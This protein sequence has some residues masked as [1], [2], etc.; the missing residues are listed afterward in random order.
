MRSDR[1][2]DDLPEPDSPL[3][4][5]SAYDLIRRFAVFA[6]LDGDVAAEIAPSLEWISLPGGAD[7]FRRGE[8]SDCAYLL[9]YGT[10]GVFADAQ[11]APVARI[12]AGETVGEMG[13]VLGR[14][15]S[16]T[17]RAL[18]DSDLVRIPGEALQRAL[19]RH[20]QALLA[21]ARIAIDRVEDG[22]GSGAR[23]SHPRTIALVPASADIDV[24]GFAVELV[25]ALARYGRAEL[26]WSVRGDDHSSGWFH[27]IEAR[28]EFVVYAGEAGASAWTGLCVRQADA[29][30]L[31]VRAGAPPA[32]W[33]ALA[34]RRL[35]HQRTELVMLHED[36][37][38]PGESARQRPATGGEVVH[39]V[40]GSEDI[41]RIARLLTG[42]ACGVVLSG[43]G[44][45]GFAHIGV[46]RAL[47]ERGVPI[48]C[49]GGTSIGAIIAAG[50]ALGWTD[51]EL[52][53]RMRACFVETNPL[54]D[55]TLPLVSLVAGRKVAAM[56][57][58]EFGG[59]DIEDMPI[60][61]FCMSSNLSAGRPEMHRSGPLW[62]WLQA[63]IAIPGVLPAVCEGGEVFVDGGAMDNL[64]VARMQSLQPGRVIGID[65]GADQQFRADGDADDAP[66]LWRFPA[67]L[68]HTRRR[69]GILRT[70]WRA[71]MVNSAAAS[72]LQRGA[73]DLLVRPPLESIDL[74][75]WRAFDRAVDCG[76]RHMLEVL[77]RAPLEPRTAA[78]SAATKGTT[79]SSTSPS[80]SGA[81]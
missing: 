76:Y 74:L 38:V 66:P 8:P 12:H 39:H 14:E 50:V 35:Q 17:V 52:R 62:R 58:R 63:S 64:P 55:F 20:P 54:S 44:A 72:A 22:R 61:Y 16:A 13:F 51:D 10:L 27:Q 60:G 34:D 31:L 5:D 37:I 2:F 70:L 43:G 78:Q 41:R 68:E 9:T 45:R 3:G 18:R 36:G 46:I 26:V 69:P 53:A 29:L 15:R 75:D 23:H 19:L 7:L 21:L 79:R 4:Q 73:A 32:H 25:E 80:E 67:W 40:R 49:I 47:R 42:N 6:E 81:R 24:A 57:R 65:V 1:S 59:I 56:L 71:G 48:D 77:D 11:A 33:P 30:L 28:N